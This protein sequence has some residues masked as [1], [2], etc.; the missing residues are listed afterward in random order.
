MH[1]NHLIFQNQIEICA[2]GLDGSDAI[3]LSRGIRMIPDV[4]FESIKNT[5]FDAVLIPGGD[6][7]VAR[8]AAVST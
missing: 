2:A 5:E 1:N 4:A 3:K 8:F 7:G 6:D